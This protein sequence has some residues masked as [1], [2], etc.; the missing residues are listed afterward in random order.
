MRQRKNKW[1][2]RIC[3]ILLSLFLVGMGS[4]GYVEAADAEPIGEV[5]VSIAHGSEMVLEQ[6]A[7]PLYAS[8]SMMTTILRACEMNDL[9]VEYT[10]ANGEAY[11][12]KA[13]G[14]IAEK[15]EGEGSGW[16]GTLNGWFCDQGFSGFKVAADSF[17]A[18]DIV[19]LFYTQNYGMDL[20]D[21]YDGTGNVSKLETQNASLIK[22]FSADKYA[23]YLY[24]ET[25]VSEVKIV[26]EAFNKQYK[27]SISC[28][29]I[30][31]RNNEAIPVTEGSVITI[32]TDLGGGMVFGT[33][34]SRSRTYTLIVTN[35]YTE[36]DPVIEGEEEEPHEHSW[37][38]WKTIQYATAVSE[39]QKRRTCSGC[40]EIETAAIDKLT[41][42]I[43]VNMSSITLKVGQSTSALK[44]SGLAEG[45][46]VKSYTSGNTKLFTVTKSGKITAAKQ[47]GKAALTIKLAS[48][49]KKNITVKVQSGTVKTKS[50]SGVSSKLTLKKGK[51]TT[52]KPVVSPLTSQQ[53][54][55][56]KSSKT[57]VATVDKNG[58]IKGIKAGKAVITV[59][60]GS[61]TKKCTVTVK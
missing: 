57:S 40:D 36:E 41:P 16:M 12:I 32:T 54:I 18:G 46:S 14:G 50:I 7:I 6:T 11:Y 58:K 23:Y 19:E 10:E 9:A 34:E 38:S 31:Y 44:V 21:M 8:D 25:P 13:I 39:G 61:V 37:N 29:G 27:V 24:S 42:T 49:L 48:G 15:D 47:T 35:T 4:T 26:T 55:T 30:I 45:D 5:Y 28:N 56:Y 33:I 3:S 22:A 59:T 43:K 17:H 2:I 52:L 60:S 20:T 51:T 1:L 53:K